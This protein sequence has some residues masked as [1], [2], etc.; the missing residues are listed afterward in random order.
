MMSVGPLQLVI[1]LVVVLLIFGT[2]K[3]RNIG[4]D[5]G[6]A[7]KEFKESVTEKKDEDL[8]KEAASSASTASTEHKPAE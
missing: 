3:L 4:K 7:I 5:L 2:S 8:E 6:G 1:I